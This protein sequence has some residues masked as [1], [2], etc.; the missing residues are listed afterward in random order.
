MRLPR[1]SLLPVMAREIFGKRQFP[2]EPE[3]DLV[4]DDPA[5]VAAYSEAGRIDGTMSANYLFHTALITRTIHGC[6]QVLDL[7]CGPA[8]QLGQVA[9]LNPQT[10]FQGVD[11]ST[12]MLA[13]AALHLDAL[14]LRNVRVHQ[15]DITALSSIADHSVDAVISTLALHHLPTHDHLHRCF[16][17]ISRVLRPGGALYLAD[18]GRL[19]NLRSVLYFAYM[20]CDR[21]P[22]IFSLDYERSLRASFELADYQRFSAA[23][24]RDVRIY[25]TFKVPFMIVLKTPDRPLSEAV[26]AQ[27]QEMR[28]RLPSRYLHD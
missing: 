12:S 27:L 8:T 7:G 20:N 23:L 15:D 14:K 24:P 5:Q 22:H 11:L 6:R 25:S 2:R 17:A 9:A 4:M 18:F 19:K 16:A 3:P 26:K 13:D 10:E 28:K 21:Q 1:L